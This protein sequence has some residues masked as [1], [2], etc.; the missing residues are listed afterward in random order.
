MEFIKIQNTILSLVQITLSLSTTTNRIYSVFRVENKKKQ[1][2]IEYALENNNI[3]GYIRY[4]CIHYKC[5]ISVSN[6]L[7][8]Q[9]SIYAFFGLKKPFLPNAHACQQ[10]TN[11]NTSTYIHTFMTSK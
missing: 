10:Y 1:H 5:L 6:G 7:D 8:I 3:T 9:L 11:I 4:N 2:T